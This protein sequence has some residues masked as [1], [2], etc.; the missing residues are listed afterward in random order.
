[1]HMVHLK[2]VD[3]LVGYVINMPTYKVLFS[4]CSLDDSLWV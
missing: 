4:M 2:A 1:M 3:I